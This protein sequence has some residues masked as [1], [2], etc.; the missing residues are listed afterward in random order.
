MYMESLRVEDG[1][2][3]LGGKDDDRVQ[4]ARSRLV[5]DNFYVPFEELCSYGLTRFQ[6]DPR[7]ATLYSQAAGQAH[8]L[9]HYQ[10]GVYRDAL[11]RYLD[12]VYAGR[13]NPMTLPRLTG[14]SYKE[15]D[16]EY[17]KYIAAP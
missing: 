4:A 2:N 8:F 10:G 9:I 16:A 11:I 6:S 12:A 14:K 17:R 1:V 3:V 5:R 13:D 7:I 15:L